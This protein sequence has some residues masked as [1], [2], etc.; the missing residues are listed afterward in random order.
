MKSSNLMLAAIATLLS[1]TVAYSTF[2]MTRVVPTAAIIIPSEVNERSTAIKLPTDM[3][4]SQASLLKLAYA[5]AKKDGHKYPQILQGIVLQETLAG[6]MK[7]FKVASGGGTT[8]FGVSQISLAAA[9]DV[10]NKYPALFDKFSFHTKTDNEIEANLILNEA[11][12]LAIA[13]KYLLILQN[14]Y[15]YA[16]ARTLVAYNRGPNN[17]VAKFGDIGEISNDG[18]VTGVRNKLA[19]LKV[20]IPGA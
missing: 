11:F 6:S 10:L 20:S 8:Y 14:T 17:K 16:G 1:F 12:N 4:S 2:F 13:S 5:T 7:S 15:N 19:V 18:Y 3:T 9:K